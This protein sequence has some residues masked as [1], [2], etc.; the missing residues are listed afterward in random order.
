MNIKRIITAT[1]LTLAMAATAGAQ[2]EV[3]DTIA[4]FTDVSTVTIVKSKDGTQTVTIISETA[5]DRKID[6]TYTIA[7][8]SGT[9]T[10]IDSENPGRWNINKLFP[11]KKS[12]TNNSYVQTQAF[13]GLYAGGLIPVGNHGAITGGWEIGINNI[14]AVEWSAGRHLPSVRIGAGLGWEIQTVGHHQAL[15]VSNG[16]LSVISLPDECH[17]IKSS[18][19]QFHLTVPLTLHLPFGSSFGLS[20]SGELHLNTYTTASS[21]WT[22]SGNTK[23]THSFKG[24]HQKTATVD[25]TAFLGWRN[26]GGVYV[27]YSPMDRWKKGYGPQ[28][29]TIAVGASL[30]F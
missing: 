28:Y 10:F 29:K 1:A 22:D 9:T 20:L 14:M 11:P 18:I 17:D 12:R 6:Y 26:A 16:A 8:E 30:N 3:T 7:G 21:S 15:Q 2:T 27:T 19:K 13:R 23:V 25:L 5:P 4:D 24:L